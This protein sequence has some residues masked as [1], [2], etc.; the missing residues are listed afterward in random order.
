MKVKKIILTIM[1]VL[2]CIMCFTA[3]DEETP[4]FNEYENLNKMLKLDYSKITLTVTDRFD[5][6]TSLTSKYV[7]SYSGKNVT[8]DYTV[9]RFNQIS[10][11]TPNTGVKS[12]VTGQAVI[13]NGSVVS[14][15]GNVIITPAV[16]NIDLNFK[17]EYFENAELTGLYLRADV[18]DASSFMKNSISCEDMKVY[19]EFLDAFYQIK[20]T[21]TNEKGNSV[22]YN[23]EFT[24]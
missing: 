3:C 7:M 17:E 19:A 10:L 12:T 22:E 11:D 1:A 2:M 16:E 6:E 18:N 5:E 13:E 4:A 24:L 20:V 8:V 9:E 23:Y 21:Y 14:N 15:S